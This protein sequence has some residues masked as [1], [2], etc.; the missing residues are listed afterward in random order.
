MPFTEE[1]DDN[2]AWKKPE[3]TQNTKLRSTGKSA[4]GNL[5]KP[6]TNLPHLKDQGPGFSKPEWTDTVAPAKIGDAN[7]AKPITTLPHIKD[8]GPFAKPEWTET[9]A[10]PKIGDTD[11]AK[12]IT[13]LPHSPTKDPSLEF[14]KPEWTVNK[15]LRSTGKGDKLQQ[16]KLERPIGG[17]RPVED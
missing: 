6:I 3:W 11:L 1:Q 16:G 5:A 10:P 15:S 13:K 14:K 4:A 7:L 17:I 9:V 2:L 8:D 12:P